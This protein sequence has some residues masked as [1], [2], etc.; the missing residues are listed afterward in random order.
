MVPADRILDEAE[1][2]KV[3]IDR[4]VRPDHAV[5][6]R[7][8]LRRRARWSGG[9]S[10]IP[11]LIGGATT[12]RTH[13][14]VKIEPGYTPAPRPMCS[15]PRARSAW[16]RACCRPDRAATASRPRP[17]PNTSRSAS[18]SPAA[19]RR[20]R[21]PRSRGARANRFR[22]DWDG[23]CAPAPSFLGV[24]AF[25]AYDLANRRATSTGRRSSPSW[26]LVGRFP[27]IL[28][29]DVVGE[30][31]RDLYADAKAMLRPHHRE[32]CSPP[33]AWSASGPPTPTATTSCSCRRDPRDRAGPLAHPA[34]ADGQERRASP[35]PRL[36]DFV[37]PIG[38]PPDYIGA[39]AVTAGHGEREIAA[40]LQGA[41]RRL[42]GDHG[43]RAGRPPGGSLRRAPAPAG[44]HRTLGLCAGRGPRRRRPDRGEIPGIRPAPGY[45]AQPDHT[46]KATLFRLLDAEAATG[47]A[48]T[49]SFAMTPA[50]LGL[51]ASTSATP[52]RTISA[53]ARSTA[54]RWRTMPAA[55][56]GTSRRPS[57]GCRRSWPTRRASMR[58]AR[59]PRPRIL[60]RASA[61]ARHETSQPQPVRPLD[62]RLPMG[63]EAQQVIGLRMRRRPW[64]GQMRKPKRRA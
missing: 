20:S 13:T 30:A 15:T 39:F 9:A 35:T 14:A 62:L 54:T 53:S 25:D 29:D 44:A 57:A 43:R 52:R 45:P 49:E 33:A 5:A 8:G 34:P 24:R 36:A 11:L 59:R 63:L 4:P 22:I 28:E 40:R 10:T 18:S 23:L 32:K 38:R 16:S 47:M 27:H 42:F 17:A 31:A 50:G 3:D 56:A 58:G 19:R 61:S 48:L 64:A 2:H 51:A 21:A 37:A 6:G 41:G 7:D 46:E 1:A 60:R 12:S 55:R 26:E